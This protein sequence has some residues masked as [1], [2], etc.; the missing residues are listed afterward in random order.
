MSD[1]QGREWVS[2]GR[3]ACCGR[4]KPW[5]WNSCSNRNV[6]GE[7][8]RR[9]ECRAHPDPINMPQELVVCW[10]CGAP[11]KTSR[12]DFGHAYCPDH[13]TMWGQPPTPR[14]L[15]DTANRPWEDE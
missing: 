12:D 4:T 15:R 5:H 2:L 10:E 14:Q 7:L 1:E 9:D 6:L 13:K 3:Q 11:R 8:A